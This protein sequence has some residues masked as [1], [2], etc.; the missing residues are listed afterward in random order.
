M[1][2]GLAVVVRRASTAI[3]VGLLESALEVEGVKGCSPVCCVEPVELGPSY[4][5][6]D[7]SR[8]LGTGPGVKP[9]LGREV[10]AAVP[11]WV[12]LDVY[13]A[14]EDLLSLDW[15]ESMLRALAVL[16]GP[17]AFELF[18]GGGR[19]WVRFGVPARQESGLRAALLGLFPA[20]VLR[21]V[22][23][24][25]PRGVPVVNELV[26][27][28]PYHRSLTLLG[29][30]GA[31]PLAVAAR[32]ISEL[33]KDERGLFQVLLCPARPEHDWH[34]N[35][36]NMVEAEERARRLSLLGG[37]SSRF[38]YDPVLPPLGEPSVVEKVRVDVAFYATLVRYAVWGR[39]SEFLQ[40]LRVATGILRFGNR[41][42]RILTINDLAGALGGECVERMVKDRLAHRPGLMLTS[43]EVA[44]LVHIP[45]A[46]TLAML[47]SIQQRTG[48]PWTPIPTENGS[49][50]FGLNEFAGETRPVEVPMSVRLRHTY[51]IGTTGSGKSKLLERLAVDDAVN[52]VGF[53]LVDPHGDLCLDVLCRIPDERMEDLVYVSFG[54]PGLVPRWNPFQSDV[55]AG[56]LA[57]DIAK[58]FMAQATV[59]G[60]RMEHNFRMLAYIVHE[61]CGTLEDFA[62]LAGQT[63]RGDELRQRALEEIEN[64]QAQRFLRNELAR[65]SARE[66]SSV[67]NKL[68][69]L[70]LDDQLGA[71]FRQTENTL[72]PREWMD[73]GKIVLVNLASGRIGADHSRFVGSLLVSLI[74]R[75]AISRVDTPIER[76]RPFF[77]YVDEF[78]QLQAATLVEALS[79]GRKYGL[80]TILAHQERGQLAKD[81][82]H[83]L[84]N[85]ATK[86]VFKPT[87]DDLNHVRKVLGSDVEPDALRA[88]RVG[89]AFIAS[90]LY[91]A[92]L[93]TQLTDK[94]RRRK[95]RETTYTLAR[96]T[97]VPTATCKAPRPR[98]RPRVYDHF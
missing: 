12:T 46:R 49:A 65:Y 75:A 52:G 91:V 30:E 45:N 89:Q 29:K 42:W 35:V 58:A 18:G 13:A 16:R 94:P 40:G 48:Q 85:A 50:C 67:N 10:V 38:S 2:S 31:S 44:S 28:G 1:R 9:G 59:T 6:F 66:L 90:S 84:G 76:R 27:V 93:G 14:E 63:A 72:H 53:G 34:F 80:G 32:V 96:S 3:G 73:S 95:P 36:V 79:E 60:A 7:S 57:D 8:V 82:A 64:P 55:P 61:L 22:E 51:I 33:G 69:R 62:E 70:L 81:L 11:R 74:Y 78:Q 77:L 24:P 19:V 41:P 88:L 21:E 15:M 68:S 4:E 5:V 54:E 39:S 47:A 37:L 87:E 23:E 20:L 86:I 43:R 26:P 17:L 71:M 25:F 83:A 56:K 92:T 98:R 97:Y